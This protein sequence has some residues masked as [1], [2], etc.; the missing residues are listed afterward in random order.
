MT[1]VEIRGR[2]YF[3]LKSVIK[4][5]FKFDTKKIFQLENIYRIELNNNK[6]IKLK[7]YDIENRE[8]IRK[9]NL[10]KLIPKRINFNPI[11]DCYETP[12]HIYA[13]SNWIRGKFFE[14]N[15]NVD[16]FFGIGSL[17]A[18][19]NS[20]IDPETE[21]NLIFTEF[22][23]G[24]IILGNDGEIHFIGSGIDISEDV[25][26]YIAEFLFNLKDR[27]KIKWF[28]KGYRRIRKY[29]RIKKILKDLEQNNET[30]STME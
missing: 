18:Q 24:H 23:N 27:T 14:E 7:I 15:G 13:I 28:L 30:K 1:Y 17:T 3:K 22:E 29:D 25:D 8:E 4:R 20:I 12:E 21:Y 10:K 5:Y 26:K 16:L 11:V 9:F 19:I 6:I 2:E